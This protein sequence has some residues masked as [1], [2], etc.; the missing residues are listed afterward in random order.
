MFKFLIVR[1]DIKVSM[2]DADLSNF[3]FQSFRNYLNLV[4][5]NFINN[6]YGSGENIFEFSRSDLETAFNIIKDILMKIVCSFI[7][8]K[9]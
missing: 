8:Y 3:I 9:S 1:F 6:I 5:F 4:F 7:I 2:T